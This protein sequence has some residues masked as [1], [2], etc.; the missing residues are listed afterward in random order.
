MAVG[1][2]LRDESETVAEDKILAYADPTQGQDN[3]K[4]YLGVVTEKPFAK[5][6]KMENHVLGLSD[7]DAS[8]AFTYKW[9][10]AWSKE[11]VNAQTPD[12][13]VW[14]DYLRR[15]E[16]QVKDKLIISY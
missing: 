11:P 13:K 14:S 7:F 5:N 12:M 8:G 2:P 16:A 9:G 10:F 6:L 1:F 3:G 15:V 4:A